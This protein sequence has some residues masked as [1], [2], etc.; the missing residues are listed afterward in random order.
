MSLSDERTNKLLEMV[1]SLLDGDSSFGSLDDDPV[2][3]PYEI[4]SFPKELGD[5][6]WFLDPTTRTMVRVYNNIEIV[7]VTDPDEDGK[8]IIK[9]SSGFALVPKEYVIEVGFN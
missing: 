8:V 4:L 6:T 9:F 7:R 3:L 5:A 2:T 1:Q